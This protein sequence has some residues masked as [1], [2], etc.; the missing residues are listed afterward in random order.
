M[1][2]L[3]ALIARGPQ[4]ASIVLGV[5][6]AAQALAITLSLAG[7]LSGVSAVGGAASARMYERH[8]PALKGIMAAHLFGAAPQV[9]QIAAAA[10][11]STPLVLTGTLAT[12]NPRDGFAIVG[13]STDSAHVIYVG[14][15]AAPGAVLLKVF[16]KWVV[17]QRGAE[18]VTLR[19]PRRNRMRGSGSG[20]GPIYNVLADDESGPSPEDMGG[21]AFAVHDPVPR[22]HL[23]DDA[24][25]MRSLGGLEPAKTVDGQNGMQIMGTA[26]NSKALAAMGL[27][28]GDVILE[29]NGVAVDAPNAPDLIHALQSG[30]VTLTVDRRGE[31]TSVSLDA[32]SMA[33]AATA[34]RQADPDL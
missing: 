15:E 25:V 32:S 16:P 1:L 4:L 9:M 12:G 19:F 2:T 23:T 24:A 5:A 34:Y 6:I 28:A 33:D 11:S 8:H 13:A 17:L 22:P 31:D 18:R 26:F 30:S 14:S 27:H 10:I 29:I 3:P 20:G 21:P 7:E